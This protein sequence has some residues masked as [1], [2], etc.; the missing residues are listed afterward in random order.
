[1]LN[2]AFLYTVSQ[3]MSWMSQAVAKFWELWAWNQ[4][5]SQNHFSGSFDKTLIWYRME[6]DRENFA[7]FVLIENLLRI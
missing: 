4:Y 7:F 6:T 2:I 1:M 5:D 3:K